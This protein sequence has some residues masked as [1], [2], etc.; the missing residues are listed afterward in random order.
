MDSFQFCFPTFP[1]HV[2]QSKVT[3]LD[4]QLQFVLRQI[5]THT[6]VATQFHRPI[7]EEYHLVGHKLSLDYHCIKLQI[8]LLEL[9]IRHM[10]DHPI[11][12]QE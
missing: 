8:S 10:S 7:T 9:Q 1:L 12:T 5:H 2:L 4:R 11:I 6:I 3:S